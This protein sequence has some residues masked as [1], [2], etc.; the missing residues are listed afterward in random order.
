MLLLTAG[1]PR[2]LRPGRVL[3]ETNPQRTLRILIPQSCACG[4]LDP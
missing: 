2:R 1:F 4:N 3:L